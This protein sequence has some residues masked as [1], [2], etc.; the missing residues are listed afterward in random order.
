MI[1]EKEEKIPAAVFP[2]Q[3]IE[4]L[5]YEVR[6]V[7]VMLDRD[8]AQL[9]EVE[10]GQMNRQVKRNKERFPED[11]CFNLAKKNGIL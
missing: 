4:N 2:Q 1:K 10:V 5:I 8:L 3:Q 11:L 7:Q 9:Y 6:G